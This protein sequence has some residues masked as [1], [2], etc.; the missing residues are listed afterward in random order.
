MTAVDFEG[1]SLCVA[2]AVSSQ[3]YAS[4]VSHFEV[5]TYLCADNKIE[6]SLMARS[7][8]LCLL[9]DRC[10]IPVCMAHAF[11]SQAYVSCLSHFEV[12]T[13]LGADI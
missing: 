12:R 4:C 5:R 9:H 1:R 8:T 2:H 11:P 6:A 10:Q 13:Y 3:A 7:L